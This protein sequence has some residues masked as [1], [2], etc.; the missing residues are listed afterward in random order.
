MMCAH[1]GKGF[2]D[3]RPGKPVNAQKYCCAKCRSSARHHKLHAA[4]RAA[5]DAAGNKSCTLCGTEFIPPYA[6][7]YQK[8]CCARCRKAAR[9]ADKQPAGWVLDAAISR[10]LTRYFAKEKARK[11]R[12]Q[13]N[14][15]RLAEAFAKGGV[16]G[17]QSL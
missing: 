12:Q 17:R 14:V 13:R 6:K 5:H 8:Y 3:L 16:S 9:Y 10:G 11:E 15:A 7:R 4:K 1:C 2:Q